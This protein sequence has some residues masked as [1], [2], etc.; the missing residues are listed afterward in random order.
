MVAKVCFIFFA[1]FF[2]SRLLAVVRILRIVFETH[3][4][5]MQLGAAS[6]ARVQPT[7]WE[8]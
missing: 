5:N 2:R 6:F 7:K 1:H 3:F 4:A 8:T